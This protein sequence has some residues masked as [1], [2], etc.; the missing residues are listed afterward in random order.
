MLLF[1]VL[2]L[3]NYRQVDNIW[4][5][6]APDPVIKVLGH[7]WNLQDG[8]L[9]LSLVVDRFLNQQRLTKRYYSSYISSVYDPMGLVS[10][11]SLQH[12]LINFEKYGNMTGIIHYQTNCTQRLFHLFKTL[13]MCN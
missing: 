7:E 13:N 10:S 5:P 8:T 3:T 4:A 1:Y 6:D 11:V 9:N 12:Q 2:W